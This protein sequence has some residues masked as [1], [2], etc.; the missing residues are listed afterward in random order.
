[1]ASSVPASSVSVGQIKTE[2]LQGKVTL[3][4]AST[5]VVSDSSAGSISVAASLPQFMSVQPQFI[6]PLQSG[7]PSVEPAAV[8]A[9]EAS[10][11]KRL[12]VAEEEWTSD[13]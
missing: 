5:V 13:S 3:E 6:V 12:R 11:P 10:E 1:M 2:Q 4:P 8:E 7:A 9:D